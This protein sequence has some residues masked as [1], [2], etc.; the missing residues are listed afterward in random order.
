M[1]GPATAGVQSWMVWHQ[2][3]WTRQAELLSQLRCANLPAGHSSKGDRLTCDAVYSRGPFS[4]SCI[5]ILCLKRGT[6]F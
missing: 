2:P 3:R 5:L 4:F 6:R 1:T